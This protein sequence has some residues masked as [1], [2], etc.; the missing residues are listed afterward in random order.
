[1]DAGAWTLSINSCPSGSAPGDITPHVSSP[2]PPA[3]IVTPRGGSGTI[4]EN[5]TTWSN[6]SYTVSLNTRP[7]LTSGLI[8]RDW[9]NNQLTFCI[10]G[11]N[12]TTLAAAIDATQTSINTTSSAGFPPTPFSVTVGGT[13]EVMTVNTMSGT[14]WTVLRGQGGTTAAPALAGATLTET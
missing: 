11:H 8:D 2:G 14:M 3:V 7:G 9:V 6:C 4:I 12:A 13:G 1:M 10:C 5:T